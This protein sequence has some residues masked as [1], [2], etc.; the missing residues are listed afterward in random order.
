MLSADQTPPAPRD[1]EDPPPAG[2]PPRLFFPDE[3]AVPPR[4]G[5][6]AGAPPRPT[7]PVTP[8][9]PPQP[10]PR[11]P[12]PPRA[13]RPTAPPRR[14]LQHRALA[15]AVFGL[16]S[17][18]ALSAANLVEHALYLVAFSV[19]VGLVAIVAGVS[20]SRRARKE[21][22]ARPRG[23]LAAV[24]L[25]ALSIAL[26]ALVAVG[27]VFATQITAYEQCYNT[28]PSAAAKQACAQKFTQSVQRQIENGR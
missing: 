22:T 14:D 17:L 1:G 2:T 19:V 18:F 24:I 6:P 11:P 7:P 13:G 27:I 21:E 15:A 28:A 10:P 5:P 8:P 4:T 20:A 23:S 16:I 12:R 26:S 9:P 25:G 3:P